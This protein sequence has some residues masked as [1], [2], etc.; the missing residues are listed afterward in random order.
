M[1][2]RPAVPIY[3][4]ISS[5]ISEQLAAVI[6]GQTT[7]EAAVAAARDAVM[8]EYERQKSR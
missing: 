7:P 2:T 5:A 4:N 6:S 3:T 8:P 1:K